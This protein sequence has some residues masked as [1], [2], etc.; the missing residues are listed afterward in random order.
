MLLGSGLGC[1]ESGDLVG[2]TADSF[3]HLS[4]KQPTVTARLSPR[5]VVLDGLDD[6]RVVAEG[7]KEVV[8]FF[9]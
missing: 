1:T 7:M 5:L 4:E 2:T 6:F 3:F 8:P 9:G